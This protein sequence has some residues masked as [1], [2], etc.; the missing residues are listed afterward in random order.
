[1]KDKLIVSCPLP[2]ERIP[3]YLD[4]IT[5]TSKGQHF[6]LGNILDHFTSIDLS[7]NNLDGPIREDIG[8]LKSLY[9]LNLSPK[10]HGYGYGIVLDTG[11][12]TGIHHFL[13]IY[14]GY[15]GY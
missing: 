14:V 7:C 6:E 3:K 13:K 15:N 1:M 4:A 2:S 9:D 12:G 11:T 10:L 5:V 8:L